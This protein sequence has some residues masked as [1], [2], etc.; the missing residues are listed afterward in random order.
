MF[1]FLEKDLHKIDFL[2]ELRLILLQVGGKAIPANSEDMG[3]RCI[4]KNYRE[5]ADVFFCL[6]FDIVK[7]SNSSIALRFWSMILTVPLLTWK[8]SQRSIGKLITSNDR[9]TQSFFLYGLDIF[10][11]TNAKQISSIGLS[12]CLSSDDLLVIPAPNSVIF[13][14]NLV[15]IGMKCSKLNPLFGNSFNKKGKQVM[16]KS[17]DL[18]GDSNVYL[19]INFVDTARYFKLLG[20]VLQEVPVG[21]FT[22]RSAVTWAQNASGSYIPIIVS[23]VVIDMCKGILLDSYVRSLF[24]RS[25]DNDILGTDKVLTKKTERDIKYENQLREAKNL[26]TTNLAAAEARKNKHFW[27]KSSVW[28]KRLSSSMVC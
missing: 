7:Q 14:A 15:Q 26:S 23:P 18:N 12:S 4:S 16:N 17:L 6:A 28:A 13:L 8:I 2:Y 24:L 22:S 27:G 10:L 5:I 11:R 20:I 1:F 9:T 3:E 25:I 21:T 19:M